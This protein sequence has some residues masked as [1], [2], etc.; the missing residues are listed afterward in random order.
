MTQSSTSTNLVVDV[1]HALEHVLEQEFPVHPFEQGTEASNFEALMG[2]YLAMSQA[3]PYLQ[4]GSQ[5][6]MIFHVMDNN[7]DVPLDVEITSV[8]GNFLSWDET[9]GN[10]I[11]RVKGIE[12]LPQIL[13]THKHFHSAMLKHDIEY[14]FQKEIPPMY[15][16]ITR[17]YLKSLYAGLASLDPV[18]RCAY[19]V[20]FEA[21]AE[22]MITNLWNL[23][24]NRFEV[25]KEKLSYFRAHVGGDDPAEV[26]HVATTQGM[27][28]R[29]VPADQFDRFL[30]EF[31][32]SYNL[33]VTWCAAIMA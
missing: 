3:F 32:K 6:D 26:Y 20:S 4:A 33:H 8:V 21:H 13:N 12:A 31:K 27:V 22:R 17:T 10:Y 1:E 19:M 16:D 28:E 5:K 15:S 30:G 25:D 14:I 11:L 7:M 23:L 29:I 18:V 9:G 2:N 24:E